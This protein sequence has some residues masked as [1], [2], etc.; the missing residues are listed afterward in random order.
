M[1]EDMMVCF[2]VQTES[3]VEG[4]EGK[5]KIPELVLPVSRSGF[6]IYVAGKLITY[7]QHALCHVQLFLCKFLEPIKYFDAVFH[8]RK[9][10]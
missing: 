8:C 1:L 2:N 3:L 6:Q 10:K 7:L 5:H 4:A 9:I